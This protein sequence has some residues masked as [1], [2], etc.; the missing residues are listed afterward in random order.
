MTNFSSLLRK[1]ISSLDH[2]PAFLLVAWLVVML[3]LPMLQVIFGEQTL[4]Q[5]LAL[6]VLLHVA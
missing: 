1:S 4:L 3:S 6:A 2:Y 5:G